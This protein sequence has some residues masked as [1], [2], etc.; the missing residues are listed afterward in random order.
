MPVEGGQIGRGLLIVL[1]V[2]WVVHHTRLLCRTDGSSCASVFLAFAAHAYTDNVLIATTACVF[3]AFVDRSVRARTLDEHG[4]GGVGNHGSSLEPVHVTR[5]SFLLVPMTLWADAAFAAGLAYV[6]NSGGASI[7]LIDMSTQKELRRDPG[8]ARAA[9]PGAQSD[10]K[11]LL[12]GDT[13]GN[14]M[15][16]LDPATASV[17][18]RVPMAD[19]Y[20]LGFS[21]NGK[22]LR[23]QRARPESGRCLRR[24]KHAAAEALPDRVDAEPPGL[25]AGLVT[26]VRELQG[27]DSL[28]AIDLTSSRC[29]GR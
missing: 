7:S 22:F 19:P 2:L 18:K 27:T 6:V 9:S 21:P 11:S 3:F 15:L 25:R 28:V 23:G 14:E 29:C 26:G 17:Q 8:A 1:F 12:V 20:Q 4:R 13:V 5:L 24:G 10:G 16:F